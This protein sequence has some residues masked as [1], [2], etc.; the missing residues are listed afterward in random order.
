MSNLN[1]VAAIA[2]RDLTKFLRDPGRLVTALVFPA[3][4]IFLLGGTLQLNLGKS[5]GFNFIAFTVTGFLGMNFSQSTATGL[6][7]LMDDRQNDFAQEVFVSPISRYAIVG[8]KIVGETAV[9][10]AQVL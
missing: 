4:M 3:A 9:A 2:A 5:A 6:S 7:S 1:A 10:L 8:G